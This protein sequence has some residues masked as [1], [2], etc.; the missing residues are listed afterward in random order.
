MQARNAAARKILS[1]CNLR[2][3]LW[4]VR[5]IAF[6]IPHRNRVVN[7]KEFGRL[8]A[9][10]HETEMPR[11]DDVS[12]LS[13][14]QRRRELAGILAAGVTRLHQLRRLNDKPATPHS[15]TARKS[16]SA[17]LEVSGETV[18]SVHTG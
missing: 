5:A 13:P 12:E 8:A 6:V 7:R 1:W 11:F 14:E 15:E 2:R 17:C 16:A 18:L 9:T 4:G 10:A 3:R